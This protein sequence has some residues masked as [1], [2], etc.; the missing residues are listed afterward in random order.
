MFRVTLNFAGKAV[1]KYNFNQESVCIG[2]DPDCEI[3]ID[4]IGVSRRHATIERANGDYIL[5]D[6]KSHNG[7]F[8]NG[9]RIYHHQLDDGDEFFIGKYSLDFE[10]LEMNSGGAKAPV[11]PAAVTAGMQ[12]M[13][14]RLDKSEIERI[15]GA[16]TTGS[17]PKLAVISPEAEQRAILLDQPWCVIGSD[18]SASVRMS[19]F[20]VPKFAAVLVRNDKWFHVLSVHGRCPVRVGGRKVLEHQLGDGEVFEVGKWKFRFAMS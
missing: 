19:G 20:L 18:E 17:I 7:T 14:F 9:Q 8:V 10:N 13:T 11:E 6:L 16:S 3:L 1:R 4:N 15:M 5:T 2:R 12:D